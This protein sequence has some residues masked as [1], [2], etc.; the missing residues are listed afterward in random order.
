MPDMTGYDSFV[1]MCKDS[2]YWYIHW[3]AGLLREII[4]V[5]VREGGSTVLLAIVP[6]NYVVLWSI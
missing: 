2:G 4:I 1:I 6:N 5:L 3:T